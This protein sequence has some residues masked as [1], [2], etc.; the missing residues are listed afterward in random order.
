[1]LPS[2]LMLCQGRAPTPDAQPAEAAVPEGKVVGEAEV[3]A[4]VEA[5][6]EADRASY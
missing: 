5:E 1:M 4:E 2:Q 6:G 3:E